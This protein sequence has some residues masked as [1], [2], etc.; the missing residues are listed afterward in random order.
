MFQRIALY[1]TLGLTLDLMQQSMFSP[2]FWCMI[3]I[4][5]AAEQL[6]RMD[7]RVQTIE[8]MQSLR[9]H[10]EQRIEQLLKLEA[11]HNSKDASNG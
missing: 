9:Q 4:V 7:A 10:I 3:A 6:A 5:W 2:G 1:A 11:E 8:D